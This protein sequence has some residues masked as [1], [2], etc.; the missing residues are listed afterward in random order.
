MQ[1]IIHGSEVKS[2]DEA[3]I[4]DRGISS[5]YLM[6]RAAD[7][8]C[9]WFENQFDRKMSIAVVC[10][11]GN[12]GGDGLAISRILTSKGYKVDVFY[13]GDLKMSSSDFHHNLKILP[14]SI[15]IEEV[16]LGQL[17]C[18]HHDVVVD[19]VFG[20]GINR[21]L[22]GSFLDLITE[23][24]Q[25]KAI[26][27]AVDLPSG[28][29][30]D[31]KLKG[32]AFKA[33]YTVSF[34]FPKLSLLFPEHGVYTG[35]LVVLDIGI[36]ESFFEPFASRTF[37]VQRKDLAER[38]KRFNRFS[39]K[40]NYGK[41]MLI[42]GSYGK[43]GAIKMSSHAALRTGSGLVSCFLP[44]CGVDA[45]QV[46]LPEVMVV[47]SEGRDVLKKEGLRDLDR[48]DALGIGPGMGTSL[49]AQECLEYALQNF[50]KPI[51]L[52]ADALNILSSNSHLLV[53]LREN[54]LLTP[55]VVEFERLVG[56][57]ANHKER[58]EKARSFCHT[59]G[60]FIILKG[61]NTMITAP[62][63]R[64]FFN[65][66]GSQ[67]MATGGAGDVLTGILT[68]FLGQGYSPENAAVCGV[69]HHGL[70]GELASVQRWRGTTATDII[71]KIPETFAFVDG[72]LDRY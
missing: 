5:Y 57:C 69:Y 61:A 22:E 66:S 9:L 29:P 11:I 21:P 46:S 23:L 4:Q 63:G 26:K 33:D 8:F 16:K 18:V 54:M 20:V 36:N 31:T 3:Y 42:G 56:K 65:S 34:Q 17:S 41:V 60:C 24:N 10:G 30:A 58:M 62:D 28:L 7:A 40:G 35:E 19:A 32:D 49:L 14:S 50:Q 38:H 37:F 55:H 70:A 13:I 52:D 45:L 53:L 2:L 59:Y 12:N 71:D 68:S 72:R 25:L 1:K 44:S 67:Y 48:F 43:I 6:E 15:S 27:I 64:Q 47:R 51:V 39:H